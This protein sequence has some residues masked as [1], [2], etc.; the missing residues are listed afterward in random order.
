MSKEK[1]TSSQIKREYAKDIKVDY[2]IIND[3]RLNVLETLCSFL[4]C[5]DPRTKRD[6]T[7]LN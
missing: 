3:F 6:I 2:M 5:T 4:G 7:L 1:K